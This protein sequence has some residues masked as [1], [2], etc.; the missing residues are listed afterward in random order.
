MK[1]KSLI[2]LLSN[3]KKSEEVD[4]HSGDVQKARKIKF[5]PLKNPTSISVVAKED[6]VTMEIFSDLSDDDIG[7]ENNIMENKIK[8]PAL[9]EQTESVSKKIQE[10]QLFLEK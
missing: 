8:N 2:F 10:V 7:E 4:D 6:A 1:K 5:S 3:L 9:N